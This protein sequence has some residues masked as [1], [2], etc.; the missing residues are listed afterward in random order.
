MFSQVATEQ[1]AANVEI[2][3]IQFLSLACEFEYYF[4]LK[5]ARFLKANK[6]LRIGFNPPPV[7]EARPDRPTITLFLARKDVVLS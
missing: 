6:Y 1:N 7:A 5:A 4:E 3:D 2:V